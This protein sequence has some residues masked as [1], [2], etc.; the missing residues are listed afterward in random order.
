MDPACGSGAFP[1]GMLQK[2]V[3]M[4]QELDPDAVL[5]FEK[6]TENIDPLFKKEIKSKFDGGSLNYIR[7]LSVIKNSIFGIDLQPIA[8]EIS[9]LRCF[10]SLII[11]EKVDDYEPNRGINPLPNL[12]FKFIIANSLVRLDPSEQISL[13]EDNDHINALKA[14]RDE[15]FNSDSERRAE[16]K[17]D[18]KDI[19]QE[20]LL[21][22]IGSS[23]NVSKRY[24]QLSA[25]KPFQNEST[26]WFDADWMFGIKEDEGFDIVIGNPPYIQLQSMKELSKTL[27]KPLKYYKSYEATGDIYTLFYEMGL[28]NLSKN[29]VLCFITSNKWMRA[30]YGESLRDNVFQ[31]YQTELLV[32]LGSGVFESATVDTNIILISNKKNTYPTKAITLDHSLGKSNMSDFIKQN[33]IEISF[34]KGEPWVILTKI[35]QQIKE[36]IEKYGIPLSKWDGIKINRGILTGCNEAFIIDSEKRNEILCGCESEEERQRTDNIIRP[37]LRGRDIKQGSYEWSGLYIINT[38]NGYR[39]SN[40]ELVPR[41]DIKNYPSLKRYMDKY[42]EAL[43]KRDDKGDT[44]YNLRSCAYM[45]DL[46]NQKIVYSEIVQKPQFYFD[47]TGEFIPE[48][49]A[50]YLYAKDMDYLVEYLNNPLSGWIFK[51]YYAGGGLGDTGYRY[52]KAFFVNLPIP[53]KLIKNY[54]DA[55]NL[56]GEEKNYI[57]SSLN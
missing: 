12:D 2:I 23:K 21:C 13:F 7:K 24:F 16:L 20:M 34:K 5:W 15:Y 27:Y 29:G 35:E 22:N 3:Y 57:E 54:F 11:E 19:Q 41:I 31:N 51:K 14:V 17:S 44:P 53:I 38:H 32:D 39:D 46:Y 8:V 33:T 50:F 26:D 6:T 45:D 18:F 30:G 47:K 40:G 9:R 43:K 49:S 4:L 52:K 55:F 25:W 42:Y 1:I 37:I 56:T 10:L 48:A 28:Y 36:K